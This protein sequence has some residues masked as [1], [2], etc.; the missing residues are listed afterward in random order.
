MPSIHHET[1]P[2]P[3]TSS[4]RRAPAAAR[5][6]RDITPVSALDEVSRTTGNRGLAALLAQRQHTAGG[7]LMLAPAP[8]RRVDPRPAAA[9]MPTVQRLQ[10]RE[11]GPIFECTKDIRG[12]WRIGERRLTTVK[13]GDDLQVLPGPEGAYQQDETPG[14]RTSAAYVVVQVGNGHG[15]AA[16]AWFAPGKRPGASE[17]MLTSGGKAV[18]GAGGTLGANIDEIGRGIDVGVLKALDSDTN[19]YADRPE[20]QNM[21]EYD[22]VRHMEISAGAVDATANIIGLAVT[23]ASWRLMSRRQRFEA[24]GQAGLST[25]AIGADVTKMVDSTA[26]TN[27]STFGGLGGGG[28]TRLPGAS[29]GT[30]DTDAASKITGNMAD[31]AGIILSG[32]QAIEDGKRAWD[33][34]RGLKDTASGERVASSTGEKVEATLMAATSAAELARAAAAT[35]RGVIFTMTNSYAAE[36]IQAVPVLGI[37]VSG[38][39]IVVRA[40]YFI[41]SHLHRGRMRHQKRDEKRALAGEVGISQA[42]IDKRKWTLGDADLADAVTSVG[43]ALVDAG[44][45][46]AQVRNV[47][48][49]SEAVAHDL[50][51]AYKGTKKGVKAVL[52]GVRTK[53]IEARAGLVRVGTKLREPDRLVAA[54]GD[55]L[56]R[57]IGKLGEIEAPSQRDM[58]RWVTS[59]GA[60]IAEAYGE[61]RAFGHKSVGY[62]LLKERVGLEVQSRTGQG[63]VGGA[64]ALEER[65]ARYEAAR[66]LELINQ[67]G[68]S[69]PAPTSPSS[70]PRSSATS[71]PSRGSPPVPAPGSRWGHLPSAWG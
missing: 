27:D 67:N 34:W 48:L 3:T 6:A 54:A 21:A 65:F 52:K 36:T 60:D 38:L 16:S 49:S 5:T 28:D 47:D 57:A 1:K 30:Y 43:D 45:K 26:K 14:S 7:T 53:A 2:A 12:I 58:R 46:L 40:W 71:P 62:D 64:K 17:T 51:S 11:G 59:A 69:G 9:P 32:K 18:S 4:L 55:R 29:Y 35:A 41:K 8:P 10:A 23:L 50:G 61:V 33:T 56:D 15:A 42:D 20:N 44:H 22:T 66:E 31:V 37:I 24:V 13:P 39:K 70:S 63:N 25:I 19:R 68:R